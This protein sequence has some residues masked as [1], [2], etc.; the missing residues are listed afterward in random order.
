ME[1]W[2]VSHAYLTWFVHLVLDPT[3]VNF[4]VTV[5]AQVHGQGRAGVD[6]QCDPQRRHQRGHARLGHQRMP[7]HSNPRSWHCQ[8]PIPDVPFTIAQ[9]AAF[10]CVTTR[11][12]FLCVTTRH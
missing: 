10:L 9:R 12:P 6:G 7:Y 2:C 3:V 1:M 5:Y 11:P 4:E 8:C